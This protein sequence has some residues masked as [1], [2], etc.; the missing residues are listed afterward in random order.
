MT[1]SEDIEAL[2][3][4][5]FTAYEKETGRKFNHDAVLRRL[6]STDDLLQQLESEGRAFHDWRNKHRKLWSCLSAFLTP[7]AAIG[8]IGMGAVQNYPG[9]AA[10]LGSVL[11]LILVSAPRLQRPVLD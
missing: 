3:K 11:Y 2:W 9:A 4:D 6:N 1:D 7:I 8:T 5:A 10:V